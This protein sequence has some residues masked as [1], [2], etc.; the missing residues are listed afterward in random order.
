MLIQDYLVI[1]VNFVINCIVKYSRYRDEVL[2]I[3]LG[4][5]LDN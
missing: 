2:H 5:H 4:Q 3:V 1:L